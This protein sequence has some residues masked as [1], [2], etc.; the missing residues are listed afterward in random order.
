VEQL[1]SDISED[2]GAAREILFSARRRRA[3]EEFIDGMAERN[4]LRSR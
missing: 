2:G 1:V 4:S 3:G